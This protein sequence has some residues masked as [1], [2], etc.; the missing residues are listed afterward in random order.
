MPLFQLE[1]NLDYLD[2]AGGLRLL[3][4][5]LPEDEDDR[6]LDREP[7]ADDEPEQEDDP[8]VTDG[9]AALDFPPS[10]AI[11]PNLL[12]LAHLLYCCWEGLPQNLMHAIAVHTSGKFNC[13]M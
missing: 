2:F 5:S 12:H 4:V 8:E 10:F 3:E 11:S 7:D 13:N 9:D 6:D 1:S